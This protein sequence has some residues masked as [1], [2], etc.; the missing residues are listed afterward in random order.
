MVMSV[1]ES[2]EEP[3]ARVWLEQVPKP[4]PRPKGIE[5]DVFISYRSV[6]RRWAMAL[7]DTLREAGYEIFLDQ[8]ELAAGTELDIEL[9]QHLSKSASAVLVWTD[10]AS[11]SEWVRAEHRK[12]MALKRQRKDFHYVVVKLDNVELP[13]TDLGAIYVD[14]TNYPDGPRGGELLRLM[15]GLAGKPLSRDAVSAVFALDTESASLLKEVGA[16]V[17]LG[18]IDKLVALGERTSPA[19]RA[20]SI[21]L[22][23]IAEGL[24]SLKALPQALA[25]LEIARR[26]FPASLRPRQLAALAYRRDGQTRRAQEILSLLY[27]EG[28]RDPET[29]GIYAATW[30]KRYEET[31]E[32][33]HLKRSQAYYADAFRLSPK[34]YYVGLNA[35][36]K[37]ALLGNIAGAQ[38]LVEQVLPLVSDAE[39]GSDYYKTVSHAEA[40][41]LER[42]LDMARELYD[43]SFVKHSE[44]KGDIDS[45]RTQAIALCSALGLTEP[46]RANLLEVFPV[47]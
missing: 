14:F 18:D 25:V 21:P 11:E 19:L 29:L 1:D 20:T 42:E 33:R 39:D 41:L 13:F 45:T 3:A 44:R 36:S 9:S 16:A 10:A 2:A 38:T 30:A 23:A 28:H 27:E 26:Y 12:I 32:R 24:I 43:I 34:D 47:D 6:N 37:L 8:Y 31:G 4:R 35:A 46:E 15:F 22:S 17:Q 7:Y 5:W 40:R